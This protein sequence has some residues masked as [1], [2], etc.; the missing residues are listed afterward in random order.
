MKSYPGH[1][2]V[3]VHSH[4]PVYSVESLINER[5]GG[6]A[7]NLAIYCDTS[8]GQRMQLDRHKTLQDC[9]FQGGPRHEPQLVELLYNYEIEFNDCPLLMCD[10]YFT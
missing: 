4:I 3:F 5:L 10:H 7:T 6:T 9:G 8:K 2:Q 1:F